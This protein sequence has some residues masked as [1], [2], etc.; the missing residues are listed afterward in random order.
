MRKKGVFVFDKALQR[1]VVLLRHAGLLEYKKFPRLLSPIKVVRVR[2]GNEKEEKPWF[3]VKIGVRTNFNPSEIWLLFKRRRHR[4]YFSDTKEDWIHIAEFHGFF[5]PNLDK[6]L[7][8]TDS[9]P[10]RTEIG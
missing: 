5:M 4:I 6:K 2:E 10:Y 9:F 8:I 3:L 1:S 7:T